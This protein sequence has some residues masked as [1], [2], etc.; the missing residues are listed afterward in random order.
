MSD[1]KICSKCG[2]EMEIGYIHNA[3]FWTR[4]R[5]TFGFKKEGRLFAYKCKN[6]GYVDF[7][8]EAKAEG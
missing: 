2:G 4:G 3:P 5:S 6:C 1:S 7:Y 8:F